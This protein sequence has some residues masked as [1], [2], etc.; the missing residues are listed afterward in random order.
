MNAA[1]LMRMDVIITNPESGEDRD[2]FGDKVATPGEPITLKGW[3]EQSRRSEDTVGTDRQSE[4]WRLF[5]VPEAAG[6]VTGSA[7]AQIGDAQFELDGPPWTATH[8]VSGQVT[9]VEGTMR[10][11]V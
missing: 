11:V 5:L 6:R 4:T 1:R 2:D 10:R 8:P 3:Y 7:T 9:H